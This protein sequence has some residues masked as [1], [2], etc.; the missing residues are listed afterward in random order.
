MGIN[1]AGARFRRR[2]DSAKIPPSA[3]FSPKSSGAHFY[4]YA[5]PINFA[6]RNT[7]KAK[8][9][10]ADLSITLYN[11]TQNFDVLYLYIEGASLILP[12]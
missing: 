5:I 2:D 10:S 7:Q 4:V 8:Q 12:R 1:V 3:H 6:F 11:L 9:N